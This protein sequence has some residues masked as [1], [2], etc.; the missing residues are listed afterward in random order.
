MLLHDRSGK[1]AEYSG[2][3]W[4]LAKQRAGQMLV[5]GKKSGELKS[6]GQS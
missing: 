6:V 4:V 5:E 3:T 2:F 1:S